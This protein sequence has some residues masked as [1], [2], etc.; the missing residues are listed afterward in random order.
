[1]KKNE[2]DPESFFEA[3]AY[4]EAQHS[5]WR[6]VIKKNQ[7]LFWKKNNA[8]RICSQLTLLTFEVDNL[9]VKKKARQFIKNKLSGLHLTKYVT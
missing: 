3:S 4:E 6:V 5:G 2:W 8:T 7:K 1:M 9:F